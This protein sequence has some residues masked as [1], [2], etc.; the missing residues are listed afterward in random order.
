MRTVGGGTGAERHGQRGSKRVDPARGAQ[1]DGDESCDGREA[2]RGY[3]EP[4]GTVRWGGGHA[5]A[6]R[7]RGWRSVARS[8]IPQAEPRKAAAN[9][10][11]PCSEPV[12]MPLK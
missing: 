5:K 11:Q 10:T 9:Q 3:D 7:A 4:S 2:E 8:R 1:V 12:A 6:G